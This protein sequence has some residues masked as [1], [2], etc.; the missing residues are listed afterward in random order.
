MGA[1]LLEQQANASKDTKFKE[2]AIRKAKASYQQSLKEDPTASLPR[3]PRKGHR[4]GWLRAE[5]LVGPLNL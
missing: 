5:V 2:E 3:K 1:Q 4:P